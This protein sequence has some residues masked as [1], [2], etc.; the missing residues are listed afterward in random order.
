MITLYTFGPAFG[1]PDMSPFVMKAEMLLK[2]AG[3][4]Y[5]TDT[6]GFSKAPKGK[7]PYIDDDGAVVADSTFIR[8]HIEQKY[9]IDFDRGL[10]AEQRAIAWAFERMFEDHV[11]WAFLHARWVDDENF[12]RGP[13]VFFQRLPMPMRLIVPRVARRQMKAQVM[14]QGIGRHSDAEIVE[15]GTRSLDAAAA[16]LG[17]KTYMMGEEPGG[18]DATAFAFL[19]HALCP[20]FETPLRTGAERHDNVKAYVGRMAE[21]YFPDYPEMREWAA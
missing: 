16:F 18:L 6:T 15:L 12:N 10:D 9:G 1:L 13:R 14:G 19:T 7:L 11:Y 21:R 8:R 4:V 3:L 5:G 20:V 2:L 17:E